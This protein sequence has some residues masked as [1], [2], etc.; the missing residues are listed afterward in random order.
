MGIYDESMTCKDFKQ[1]SPHS[2]NFKT[3][4]QSWTKTFQREGVNQKMSFKPKSPPSDK[5]KRVGID[6]DMQRFQAE[7]IKQLQDTSTE[8]DLENIRHQEYNSWLISY[9]FKIYR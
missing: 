6:D 5:Y 1:K 4:A 3:Q 2:N 7:V 9:W 8:L